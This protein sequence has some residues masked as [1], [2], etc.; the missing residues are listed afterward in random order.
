[1]K[2]IW[3]MTDVEIWKEALLTGTLITAITGGAALTTENAY[4]GAGLL[5]L[6][7]I[8]ISVFGLTLK[9]IKEE[10]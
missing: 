7:L 10:A 5:G 8:N 1:M 2:Y 6:L 4:I 3:N 9:Q